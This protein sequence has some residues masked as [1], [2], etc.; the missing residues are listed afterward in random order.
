ML[1]YLIMIA[2][3]PW[4]ALEP[5]NPIRAIWQFAHFH[6][7]IHTLAFG[8]KYEMGEVPRWYI[9]AYLAIKLPLT[10]LAGVLAGVAAAVCSWLGARPSCAEKPC[11]S[12]MP[13]AT[14]SP[15]SSRS[16]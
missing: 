4:A 5:L 13:M 12:A 15:C 10:V 16:E 14:P 6:Y 8:Q 2:A 9:P 7:T 11:A 1:A 3:W